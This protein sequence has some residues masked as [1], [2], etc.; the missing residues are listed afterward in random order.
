LKLTRQQQQQARS[1]IFAFARPLEQALYALW[2]EGGTP[3]AVLA[4][5][6][7]FQNADGGFGHALEPDLRTPESS[8][9]ATTI[10][11][12]ILRAL[13]TPDHHPPVRGAIGYLLDTYD[14]KQ[15]RWPIVTAAAG[16]AP[17]APWWEPDAE[18][19]QRFGEFLA[20][21]RAEIA[22]YLYEYAA[23]VPAE[24]LDALGRA[25]VDH[26]EQLPARMEMHDL[27]CYVRLAETKNLP[28]DMRTRIMAR[29]RPAVAATVVREAAAWEAY[30]LPPLAVVST[31]DSPFAALFGAELE[32]NLDALVA[33]Q[34]DDGAWSPNWSWADTFPEAWAAAERDWKGVLTLTNLRTLRSFGRLG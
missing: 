3:E 13:N 32:A 9:I 30:S 23:L 28:P 25:T 33:R 7:R 5:L 31:P 16:M 14:Q 21:P 15:Q 20:N 34:G 27:L 12:Q 17:H 22:G 19:S 18:L 11:L 4:R 26:L 6:A 10:A 24:L 1:F 29:L 8:A 2:F